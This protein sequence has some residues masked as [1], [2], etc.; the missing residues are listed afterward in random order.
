M[1]SL[2]FSDAVGASRLKT[3]LEAGLGEEC[4]AGVSR[5]SSEIWRGV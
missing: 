5:P 2:Q 3:N 1:M 4:P